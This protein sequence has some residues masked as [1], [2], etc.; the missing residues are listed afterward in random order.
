MDLSPY[1]TYR[2]DLDEGPW[3]AVPRGLQRLG[4]VPFRIE[5]LIEVTGLNAAREG[6]FAPPQITGIIVG[7]RARRLHLLHGAL[8]CEDD[9]VPLA[10]LV[11]HFADGQTHDVRLAYGVHA[12][13][14]L[15][16]RFERTTELADPQSRQ[17]WAQPIQGE[18]RA[19]AGLR[20]FATAVDNPR[21]EMEIRSVDWVSL[22]SRASPVLLG[23]TV[24][25]G[26]PS[27]QQPE[28]PRRLA[29]RAYEWSDAVYRRPLTVRVTDRAEGRPLTNA[30]AHL[31][32]RDDRRSFYFG[33]ATADA[34]GQLRF[35]YPPQHT[36]GFLLL[37]KAP[38]YAPVTLRHTRGPGSG[39]LPEELEV[40]LDRGVRMGG[41]V[42]TPQGAPV[43]GA[44]VTVCAG[45]TGD[46]PVELEL[47]TVRTDA[48]GQWFSTAAGAAF[49]NLQLEVNHPDFRP[50]RCLVGDGPPGAMAQ[51]P[52]NG[53][54]T[55]LVVSPRPPK[56]KPGQAPEV[57]GP[58]RRPP[59]SSAMI[60]TPHVVSLSKGA[61]LTGEAE[62]I[63]EPVLRLVGQVTDQAGQAV[64]NAQVFL[65]P[66]EPVGPSEATV[67]PEPKD[68]ERLVFP[69]Q[70]SRTD[71]EG[72]FS[73]RLFGSGPA[74][75][76]VLAVGLAPRYEVLN[77][78]NPVTTATIRLST[79]R[80]FQG[81]VV[82]QAGRPVPGATIRVESWHQTPLVRWQART[83]A[84]GRFRWDSAPQDRFVVQ[85]NAP[86]FYPLRSTVVGGTD[87]E[88]A[89]TLRRPFMA[90]GRVVDAETGEPI[91][92]F[93]LQQG[94]QFPQPLPARIQWVRYRLYRGRN[95]QYA[96]RLNEFG[97]GVT[98]WL[99]VE[100]PGYLP[101][102][103]GPFA[104]TGW[105]TND[106]RLRKGRG[107]HGVVCLPDGQP[108]AG[109]TLVL[110][111]P[112]ESAEMVRPGQLRS[113][114]DRAELV[115]S[116]RQG[117]FEF[118]AKLE[119]RRIFAAHDKG[120]A[121]VDVTQLESTGQIVL[122]P[123]G[124]V[125][126][127]FR[128]GPSNWANR[129]VVIRRPPPLGYSPYEDP[130]AVPELGLWLR[131]QT[132]A[133]GAF[134]FE[135]VP[136]GWCEVAAEYRLQ[137]GGDDVTTPSHNVPVEVQPGQ[138]AQVTLGGT[139][140]TVVG[141]VAFRG[142][143]P[144]HAVDWHQQ[145]YFLQSRLAPPRMPMPDLSRA[146]SP[147][148]QRRA[149]LEYQQRQRDFWRSEEG[150]ALARQHRR[151]ALL[152]ETNGSFRIQDVPAGTYELQI[153]LAQREEEDGGSSYRSLGWLSREVVVPEGPAD[154]P[155]NLGTLLMTVRW[156]LR[157]G[158]PAPAA[159]FETLTG[160]TIRLQAC[161]GT[162]VLLY[163][164]ATWSG[165]AGADLPVLQQLHQRYGASGRLLIVELMVDGTR[166]AA[167]QLVRNHRTAWPACHVGS[168]AEA[169]AP[170]LFGVD[171][172]PVGIL[173]GPDGT[174]RHKNLRGP[175]LVQAVTDALEGSDQANAQPEQ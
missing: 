28:P 120:Y 95:G 127:L 171:S 52:S 87:G 7:S 6:H 17:V 154:Q 129:A 99:L 69:V 124:R 156:P 130:Q 92:R 112:G 144:A 169:V 101:A 106:F 108:V 160:Q 50:V 115:R 33:S 60:P 174:V 56:F 49:T 157:V 76:A 142:G 75:V 77:V 61:L 147:E 82:D 47:D 132:D 126:G 43:A 19:E 173:I 74:A 88:V 53:P 153:H 84:E 123:W 155:V 12:R 65:L 100:A 114:N 136:P 145:W 133:Q 80:P 67:E 103:S 96:V 117:R 13:H 51:P 32:V 73:F 125:T 116:D 72:R 109:C 18:D 121:E 48:Q 26:P 86:D 134:V 146:R 137:R 167:E 98:N 143:V 139:G 20:L 93:T 141:Q 118:P 164:H 21:P 104:N 140:R 16:P 4:G 111:Q 85:V 8:G 11:L 81:R 3:A 122:Q 37:V 148:A 36:V 149:M 58:G 170:A 105:V 66:P 63:L 128:I 10:K 39:R 45:P 175:T 172:L 24:E 163:F 23:L 30:S 62:L 31:A 78:T 14:V 55:S 89:L 1:L 158:Q 119:A 42:K 97:S 59:R 79:A 22:F 46:E 107:P 102:L 70:A 83:D 168:W 57:A 25:E 151:Y 166:R 64:T 135:R 131:T 44:E 68:R 9:G 110:A 34:N 152:F 5:G 113:E 138:T 161:R 15:P 35:D 150:R 165:P 29:R 71:L 159:E 41:R 40:A 2:L 90:Y 54:P 38:G 162:N 94:Y 27:G 91:D